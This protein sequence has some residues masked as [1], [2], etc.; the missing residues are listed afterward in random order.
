MS[1]LALK[2][3]LRLPLVVSL[4]LVACQRTEPSPVG[5]TPAQE[6]SQSQT[7][8]EKSLPAEKER[9]TT[10]AI[11]LRA[12]LVAQPKL[13]PLALPPQLTLA[14]S[15][16]R[17]VKGDRDLR[18]AHAPASNLEA[19]VYLHGMCGNSKGAEPWVEQALERGTLIV[20][21]ANVP[22]P[23]R[24]GYKWPKSA[25][26]IQKRVKAA[27][28]LVKKDRAGLLNTESVTLIGYSQGAHRAERL[29]EIAPNMYPRIILGGAPTLSAYARLEKVRALAYLGGSKEK[30]EHMEASQLLMSKAGVN[31]RFFLLPG[32]P[33]GSYGKKGP[34]VMGQVFQFLFKEASEPKLLI[35]P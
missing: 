2:T 19:L 30:R 14:R 6:W 31:A 21:R 8:K 9:L 15:I 35:S 16:E 26:A 17:P 25:L 28:A 7:S 5:I 22:C 23:D 12:A 1:T 33:H 24:P 34:Q 20:V 11:E 29:A 10:K 27:L 32:A 3:K 18:V 13:E 4:L